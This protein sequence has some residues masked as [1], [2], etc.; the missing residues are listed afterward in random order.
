MKTIPIF[1][2]R[3]VIILAIAPLTGFTQTHENSIENLQWY[4]PE[5]TIARLGK[6]TVNGITYSPDG[7]QLV[8]TSSIGLWVYDAQTYEA[9]TLFTGHTD[10]V[11]SAAYSPDGTTLASGSWDNTIRLWNTKTGQHKKTLSG[12]TDRVVSVSFSP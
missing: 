2:V 12:H 11:S 1:V 6:G 8:V 10:I 7:T 3:F 9:L 5:G 4:L